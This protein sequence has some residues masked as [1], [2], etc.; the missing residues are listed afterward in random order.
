MK[1][2][3]LTMAAAVTMLS[4]ASCR[5]DYTCTCI[6]NVAGFAYTEVRNLESTTRTAAA[7]GCPETITQTDGTETYTGTCDLDED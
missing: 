6:Y 3:L 4:F 5:K 2:T 1:K 7:G